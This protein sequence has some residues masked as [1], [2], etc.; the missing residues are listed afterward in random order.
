MEK[1]AM[2]IIDIGYNILLVCRFLFTRN[3]ICLVMVVNRYF[4]L[5]NTHTNLSKQSSMLLFKEE[6]MI[7]CVKNVSGM[8]M[9]VSISL[10]VQMHV[11]FL[12]QI[13]K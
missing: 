9:C 3:T 8:Y 10:D 1:C 11:Q 6:K 2:T 13:G 12:I 4:T 5:H 7:E